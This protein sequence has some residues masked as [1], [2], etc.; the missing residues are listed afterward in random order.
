[1][2]PESV[3]SKLDVRLRTPTP[4]LGVDELPVPWVSKTPNNPIEAI[5]Q[6]DFIKSRISRH[7]GSSPTSILDA[8]DQFAKGTR[9]IMH[10]IAL[11]KSEVQ[12]LREENERLSRRRR[13][14]KKRLRQGGSLTVG[15]GQDTQGQNDFNVQLQEESRG[16][17]RRKRKAETEQRRCGVCD[18]TRHNARS[19][20]IEVE[21]S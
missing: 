3:F 9:G 7:Q 6:S 10:Q 18:R 8:V 2:N 14:K 13:V 4:V 20:Q 19:C 21:V 12:I 17:G 11:L 15:Q 1:M 5:S 16:N